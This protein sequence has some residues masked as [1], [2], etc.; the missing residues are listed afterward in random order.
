[1]WTKVFRGY[2]VFIGL[3][4]IDS[5]LKIIQRT[6]LFFKIDIKASFDKTT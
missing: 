1:M 2:A 4:C 3:E 6:S 5:K